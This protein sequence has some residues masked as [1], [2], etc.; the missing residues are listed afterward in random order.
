MTLSITHQKHILRA[1]IRLSVN[2]PGHSVQTLPCPLQHYKYFI[3]LESDG[4][5][6]KKNIKLK[7]EVNNKG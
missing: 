7:P 4:R 6:V 3:C 1:N 2:Y 5:R